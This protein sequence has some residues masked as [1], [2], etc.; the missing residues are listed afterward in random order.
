MVPYT[1]GNPQLLGA[2][3]MPVDVQN[4]SAPSPSAQMP[5]M[6]PEQM[7]QMLSMLPS[8]NQPD[9]GSGLTPQFANGLLN[10]NAS[11]APGNGLG[12]DFGQGLMGLG[13]PNKFNING[14]W[15]G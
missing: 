10:P 11:A 1:S 13:N 14:V 3:M 8:N 5:Q 12:Y 15:N 9:V 7:Q 2:Q 6:S 4:A